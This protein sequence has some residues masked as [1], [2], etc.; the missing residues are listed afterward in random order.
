MRALPPGE[1]IAVDGTAWPY[2][3]APCGLALLDKD[4]RFTHANATFLR[5]FGYEGGLIEHGHDAAPS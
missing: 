2:A 5:W 4:G 3:E 1:D